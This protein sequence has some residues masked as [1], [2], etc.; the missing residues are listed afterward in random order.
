V[1]R[2]L[3]GAAG[4]PSG[5]LEVGS[6]AKA[7]GLAQVVIRQIH[8]A[9]VLQLQEA[10]AESLCAGEAPEWFQER[11][12]DAE[13]SPPSPARLADMPGGWVVEGPDRQVH[14]YILRRGTKADVLEAQRLAWPACAEAVREYEDRTGQRGRFLRPGR[15]AARTPSIS[16]TMW[17]ALAAVGGAF[18][19]RLIQFRPHVI[20]FR[21]EGG[22][23]D[24][25]AGFIRAC[26]LF[27]N[28][29]V[30]LGGPTATSHPSEV[31]EDLGADYVFAGEAEETFAQFLRAA[32]TPNSRDL[33]AE[34]PGLAYRYGGRIFH[35]TL[36]SDGY[37]RTAANGTESQR[38]TA[39][40]FGFSLPSGPDRGRPIPAGGLAGHTEGVY[41]LGQAVEEGGGFDSALCAAA[42]EVGAMQ[43]RVRPTVSSALLE[44]NRLDWSLLEGFDRP[45]K[46]LFFTGSRG[47]PGGCSFCAKLH[48]NRVRWKSARRLLEEIQQADAWVQSGKLKVERWPLFAY[49]DRPDLQEL[50]VAW[51]AVYDEDFF[52]LRDRAI[53]FFQLWETSD[54]RRRYRLS[55]QTNPRSLLER[56]GRVDGELLAWIDRLKPMIQL[57]GESFHPELLARWRKRHTVAQLEQAADAL[58]STRQ[59]YTV[60]ILLS[61]FDAPAEEVVDAVWLLCRAALRRPRMRIAS[62]PFTIPLYDS[63]TRRDLEYRGLLPPGRVRN[64][65]EYERPQPGWMD[66]WAAQLADRADAE[67]HFAM[68]PAYRDAAL[69]RAMEVLVE[70]IRGW[71]EPDS[72][73]FVDGRLGTTEPTPPHRSVSPADENQSGQAPL[74]KSHFDRPMTKDRRRLLLRQ[75]EWALQQVREMAFRLPAGIHPVDG[76]DRMRIELPRPPEHP[77]G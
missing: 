70:T 22:D 38:E 23:Q 41:P 4:W 46:S 76:P 77:V 9:K 59:D 55:F 7:Q 63:Q 1:I 33:A 26:R 18:V 14:F 43:S 34:I 45:M 65:R 74:K 6:W 51:A 69:V 49:T 75:A 21:L 72:N 35:N 56:T 13:L 66:P 57:G 25:V 52:L 58:E 53:E 42:E 32:R 11:C 30:V 15:A 24:Q 37:G 54:L 39:R 67:L 73:S 29:E 19:E 36:P 68:Q 12:R 48:G 50:Q 8:P 60:F 47:C 3:F 44:A 61:D 2:V 28:A 5:V 27:S 10:E 31:L 17:E 62:S 71:A 40:L 20:G 64:Y 16:A